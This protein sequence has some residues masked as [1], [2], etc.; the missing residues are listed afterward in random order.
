MSSDNIQIHVLVSG[1]VQGVFFRTETQKTAKANNVTGWVKNLDDGSVEAV[2]E[3]KKEN[4]N[5]V[6]DWCHKGSPAAFVSNVKAT[7]QSALSNF[8]G[9]KIQ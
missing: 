9:F 2:I 6:V 7:E 3:G 5:N 4:V 8:D 1:I